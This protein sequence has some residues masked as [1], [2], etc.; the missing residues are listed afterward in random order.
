MKNKELVEMC[1]P[2]GEYEKWYKWFAKMLHRKEELAEKNAIQ[3][4]LRAKLQEAIPITRKVAT[5]EIVN[6]IESYL[7][8]T[9][10]PEGDMHHID[11]REWQ[12][13]KQRIIGKPLGKE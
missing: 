5:V 4:L 12:S 10:H 1:L 3:H 7:V 6:F 11:D 9:V 13:I 2:Q 8:T